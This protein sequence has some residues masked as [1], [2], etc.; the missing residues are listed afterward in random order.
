MERFGDLRMVPMDPPEYWRNGKKI[1]PHPV[2]QEY[3]NKNALLDRIDQ[4]RLDADCTAEYCRGAG[5]ES[6]RC[7]DD[8][9]KATLCYEEILDLIESGEFDIV[10]PGV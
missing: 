8:M 9:I 1:I 10:P 4:M 3:L 2:S 5:E 7:A 6:D